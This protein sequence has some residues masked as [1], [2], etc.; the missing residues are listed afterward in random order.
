MY[1]IVCIKKRKLIAPVPGVEQNK[2]SRIL[3]SYYI[4]YPKA[5]DGRDRDHAPPGGKRVEM[6]GSAFQNHEKQSNSKGYIR[7]EA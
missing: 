4:N 2:Q 7:K 5:Q 3:F 1:D 6:L